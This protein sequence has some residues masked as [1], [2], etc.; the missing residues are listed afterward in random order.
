[1]GGLVAAVIADLGLTE[2]LTDYQTRQVWAEAVGPTLAAQTRP[3][4]LRHG[5]MEVAVPSAAWRNQLIFMK[6]D[7]I[8]KINHSM[9][10]EV[11]K[12]LKLVHSR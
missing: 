4:Q 3:L 7:I 1:M 8:A 6:G 11:V 2:K 5:K 9:G 10:R 12:D